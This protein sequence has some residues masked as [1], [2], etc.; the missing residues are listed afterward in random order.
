MGTGSLRLQIILYTALI[1]GPVNQIL[2][3]TAAGACAAPPEQRGA[4]GFFPS[5]YPSIV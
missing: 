5:S 3:T 4:S 2:G 1:A